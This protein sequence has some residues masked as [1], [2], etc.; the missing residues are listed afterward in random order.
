MS[1]IKPIKINPEL[2]KVSGSQNKNKTLKNKPVNPIK[3]NVLKKDLLARIKNHR[4]HKQNNLLSTNLDENNNYDYN[5]DNQDNY[6]NNNSSD[7][8]QNINTSDSLTQKLDNIPITLEANSSSKK[9]IPINNDHDD[10]FLQSINFL[11]TLSNKKNNTI[12]RKNLQDFPIEKQENL[13]NLPQYGCLKNGSLPTFRQLHNSTVKRDSDDVSDST[14]PKI[15]SSNKKNVTFKYNL[16]KK[17]KVVSVL[18]KN[19]ST[20]K[21]ISS[22]HTRL[23]EIKLND[24]KNYLKRHNLLKSGSNAPPDVIKKLYEQSLLTGDVRNTN[25]NSIVHNYLAE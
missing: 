16:G 1:N 25:K 15:K 4:S 24:M 19:V 18:I 2:F 7:N 11:K 5:T 13:D 23:K 8:K 12:K 9:P 3:S 6:T 14:I 10:D 22:E 21:K 17:H 20:R